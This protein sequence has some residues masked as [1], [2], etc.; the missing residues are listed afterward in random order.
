MCSLNPGSAFPCPVESIIL[1]SWANN[2]GKWR[3]MRECRTPHIF[4]SSNLQRKYQPGLTKQHASN[5][6]PITKVISLS[7]TSLLHFTKYSAFSFPSE[8]H[9]VLIRPDSM[10]TAY[11]NTFTGFWTSAHFEEKKNKIH[12][13]M[14][15]PNESLAHGEAGDAYCL[16]WVLSHGNPLI[17]HSAIWINVW[18]KNAKI[19]SRQRE[20]KNSTAF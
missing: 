3:L 17:P 1:K 19:N 11:I 5:Y 13:S 12:C 10:S 7:P 6:I 8:S 4:S 9:S 2:G 18:T 16:S 20:D 14:I 15:P